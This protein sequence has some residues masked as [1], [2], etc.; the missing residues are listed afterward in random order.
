MEKLYEL[1]NEK[2]KNLEEIKSEGV[3]LYN[4]IDQY[5]NQIHISKLIF[6]FSL[7]YL[8]LVEKLLLNMLWKFV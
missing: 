5:H 4:K 8:S 7:S 1:I 2:L 6:S 3:D